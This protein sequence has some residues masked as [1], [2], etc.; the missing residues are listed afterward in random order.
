MNLEPIVLIW[1]AVAVAGAIYAVDQLATANEDH[2]L[3]RDTRAEGPN[4]RHLR[5]LEYAVTK[6]DVISARWIV[7]QELAFLGVGLLAISQPP[8]PH[9]SLLGW[10]IVG[11]LIFGAAV[12]PLRL[13]DQRRR[14]RR[15]V[16]PRP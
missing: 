10:V 12:L 13:A 3:V 2:D 6:N 4:E 8:N 7:A 14:R 1:N 16:R 5:A 15:L 9:R 11:M